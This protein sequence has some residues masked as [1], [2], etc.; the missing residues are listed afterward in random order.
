MSCTELLIMSDVEYPLMP[1]WLIPCWACLFALN[2]VLFGKCGWCGKTEDILTDLNKGRDVSPMILLG[3]GFFW[4]GYFIWL[5][6]DVFHLDADHYSSTWDQY[7]ALYLMYINAALP[8]YIV[9]FWWFVTAR[10]SEDPDE[11][12]FLTHMI[13]TGYGVPFIA[14]YCII[15]PAIFTHIA[16]MMISYIWMVVPVFA[17]VA[18]FAICLFKIKT[19]D[20]EDPRES[21][22]V[23][24]TR[25]GTCMGQLGYVAFI[26]F[27]TGVVAFFVQ[28]LFNYGVIFYQKAPIGS[29][30]SKSDYINVIVEEFNSRNTHCWFSRLAD[31]L[32]GKGEWSGEF[33]SEIWAGMVTWAG[34][35]ATYILVSLVGCCIPLTGLCCWKRQTAVS[36]GADISDTDL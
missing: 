36:P 16:P 19:A 14:A 33:S 23:T 15:F 20:E 21:K 8:V 6:V 4:I 29:L 34:V 25:W 22:V 17:V 32:E 31:D 28:G 26:S 35:P 24:R 30:I 3:L 18:Y 9:S 10:T 13:S 11:D 2:N 12:A 27:F 1:Y 7:Q 5:C